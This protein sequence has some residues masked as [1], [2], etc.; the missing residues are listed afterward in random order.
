MQKVEQASAPWRLNH[1]IRSFSTAGKEWPYI[2]T[3]ADGPVL[4]MLPGSVGTCET[5]WKQIATLGRRFRIISVG[6]P[7]EA[8]PSRLAD[9]LAA[10]M[11][12]LGVGRAHVLGSSFGG[13]WAQFF[14]LRHPDRVMT[15]FLGNTFVEP[16]ELASN[17]LFDRRWVESASAEEIQSTWR[18]RVEGAP[19]SELKRFQL[20]M[21]SG[22]QSAANLKA[23]FL[24]VTQAVRCPP[25]SLDPSRI[26]II[27]CDDDPVI[28]P[29]S[30]RAVRDAYPG[31]AV[32]TLAR[33]GHYPHILNPDAYEDLLVK[34]LA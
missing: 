20:D 33:G 23:R 6:Y 12:A 8:D 28:P 11:T 22:R 9:G 30:R 31:A 27:D 5:F 34:R 17:P 25:L 3:G 4:V 26:V 13:Y 1:L 29:A 21:L 15:L 19:D 24:G 7:D 2:D 10:L 18:A 14:A 16:S 32:C